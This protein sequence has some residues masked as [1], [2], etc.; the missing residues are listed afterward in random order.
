MAIYN[1]SEYE[2]ERVQAMQLWADALSAVIHT[3]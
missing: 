2:S 1:R 3:A